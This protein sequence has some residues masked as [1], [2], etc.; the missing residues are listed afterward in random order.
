MK[1]STT[2]ELALNFLNN[3]YGALRIAMPYNE[4]QKMIRQSQSDFDY[5]TTEYSKNQSSTNYK[6]LVNSMVHLQY[7]NQ[8]RI[9]QDSLISRAMGE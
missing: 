9:T 1:Y 8:K 7:W 2:E 6:L 5:Y 4:V 3:E